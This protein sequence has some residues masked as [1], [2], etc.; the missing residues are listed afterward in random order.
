MTKGTF[1]T[2][3]NL[4]QIDGCPYS[5]SKEE[6]ERKVADPRAPGNVIQLLE[7]GAGEAAVASSRFRSARY[8]SRSLGLA[9]WPEAWKMA[10]RISSGKRYALGC[11][12]SNL[13]SLSSSMASD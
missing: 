3:G 1:I 5:I 10:F 13:K 2:E 8:A 11:I 7:M 6:A 12:L 9:S 4:F